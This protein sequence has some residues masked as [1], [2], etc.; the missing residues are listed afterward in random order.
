M[1]NLRR[2]LLGLCLPPIAFTILDAT[3]TLAGQSSAYWGGVYTQ[4]NEGSPAFH[5]LLTIHPWAFAL[6]TLV[7]IGAF[8]ALILLLPD[9][10]A[11]ILSIAT[12]FGHA[13]G[14]ATW[15]L[16]QFRYS[17]QACN[18]LF[19]LSAIALGL[20]IRWGWHAA[21]PQDDRPALLSAPWRWAIVAVLFAVGIY[22]ALWP[23]VL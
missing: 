3:L 10:L 12:T 17:Y 9:T 4:V 15:I 19:L 18:A 14:A 6:G 16:W 20:G 22:V 8:V 1:G 13:V 11:L 21:P 23:S 5:H 2:R 7:W